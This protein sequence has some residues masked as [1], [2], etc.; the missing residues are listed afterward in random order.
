MHREEF[1]PEAYRVL[2][3]KKPFQREQTSSRVHEQDLLQRPSAAERKDVSCE[4]HTTQ[5]R[6][7]SR[8]DLSGLVAA[9][10]AVWQTE[11][12]IRVC[13]QTLRV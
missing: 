1:L 5:V 13:P 8:T 11:T 6:R 2:K 3:D 9:K 7:S 12:D 4:G 10:K